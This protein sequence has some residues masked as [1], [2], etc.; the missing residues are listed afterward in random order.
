[1]QVIR[2]ELYD[3]YYPFYPLCRLLWIV[4]SSAWYHLI[5]SKMAFYALSSGEAIRNMMV[6]DSYI[7]I[8]SSNS[9]HRFEDSRQHGSANQLLVTDSEGKCNGCVK[10]RSSYLAIILQVSASKCQV[11]DTGVF[12]YNV[13][14]SVTVVH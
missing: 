4:I 8:G 10:G 2:T 13:T 12:P 9:L 14:L 5:W 1:M 6:E 7:L 3:V 11:I